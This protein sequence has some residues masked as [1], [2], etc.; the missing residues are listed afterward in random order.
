MINVEICFLLCVLL[1]QKAV[2][3]GDGPSWEISTLL[4][5][6]GGVYIYIRCTPYQNIA[7]MKV[8]HYVACAQL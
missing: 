8:D 5:T 7:Y 2:V 4:P 6:G 3:V 1:F